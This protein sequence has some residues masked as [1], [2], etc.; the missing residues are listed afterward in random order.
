MPNPGQTTPTLSFD[1]QTFS[2]LQ[3]HTHTPTSEHAI[4]G[5]FTASEIHFVFGTGTTAQ[6]VVGL[7]LN[8]GLPRAFY[9]DIYRQLDSSGERLP[10]PG[11]TRNATNIRPNF[12]LL[13]NQ[14]FFK[15]YWTYRGSL[16]LPAC[17]EGF[18]WFVSGKI[19]TLDP[20]QLLRLNAASAFSVRALQRIQDQQV[21]V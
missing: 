16:T 7:F 19:E 12:S 20:S 9:T 3:W 5:A 14:D 10:P 15:D 21:N 18:R 11:S 6:A 2:L 17:T 1:G 4:G 13:F 8:P